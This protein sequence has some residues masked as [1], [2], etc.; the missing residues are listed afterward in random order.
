[1]PEELRIP[2]DR[3]LVSEEGVSEWKEQG[4][5]SSSRHPKKRVLPT[6]ESRGVPYSV[7]RPRLT[8]SALGD[9]KEELLLDIAGKVSSL[10]ENVGDPDGRI[11]Q[12]FAGVCQEVQWVTECQEFNHGQVMRVRAWKHEGS[13]GNSLKVYPAGASCW[14]NSCAPRRGSFA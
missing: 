9:P 2:E 7:K 3:S 12:G 6:R 14:S 11:L 8:R 10:A 5:G 1:M 13:L 4:T